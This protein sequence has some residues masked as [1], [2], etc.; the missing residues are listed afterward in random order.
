[1][2]ETTTTEILRSPWAQAKCLVAAE[3]GKILDATTS[4]PAQ[5]ADAERR[6]GRL[7]A[8]W[9]GEKYCYPKFQFDGEGRPRP[10]LQELWAVL[11]RE[12][13]GTLG[14]EAVLWMWAPDNALEGR[15]PAEVFVDD[16]SRVVALARCR[17]EGS[18]DVD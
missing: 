1:V 2:D 11:P 4:D 3:V 6:A 12:R 18:A 13:S 5:M 15:A 17:R 10:G 8:A 9:D 16:P 7:L 14:V